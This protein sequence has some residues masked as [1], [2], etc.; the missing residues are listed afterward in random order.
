MLS[1]Y[2]K[3][4]VGQALWIA[5]CLAPIGEEWQAYGWQHCCDCDQK[6]VLKLVGIRRELKEI[7]DSMTGGKILSIDSSGYVIYS[8]W[9]WIG[10]ARIM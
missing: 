7:T 3:G 5:D 8:L 10:A 9:R 4:T 1:K 6:F 2:V